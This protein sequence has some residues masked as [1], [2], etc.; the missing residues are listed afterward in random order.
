MESNEMKQM[1]EL[2]LLETLPTPTPTPIP[3]TEEDNNKKPWV[4]FLRDYIVGNFK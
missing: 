1:R 4:S 3:S 2:E